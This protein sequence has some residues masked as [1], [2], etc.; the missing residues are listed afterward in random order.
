MTASVRIIIGGTLLLPL[1]LSC[2]AGDGRSGALDLRMPRA[3]RPLPR[4]FIVPEPA[5][6]SPQA[7]ALARPVLAFESGEGPVAIPK[8]ALRVQ[9]SGD[10]SLSLR[11]R[12]HG[13]AVAWRKRF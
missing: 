11:P 8:G 12:R 10:A 2:H 1:W 4:L 5:F 9:L 7:P 6:A 13:L 3:E